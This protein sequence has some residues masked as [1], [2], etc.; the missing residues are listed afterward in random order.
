MEKIDSRQKVGA[1]YRLECQPGF[2]KLF[3]RCYFNAVL[4]EADLVFNK[5]A[6]LAPQLPVEADVVAQQLQHSFQILRKFGRWCAWYL[7][8]DVTFKENDILMSHMQLS[9][10]PIGG[11]VSEHFR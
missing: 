6:Q 2:T 4:I 11:D 3:T 9:P 5:A 10:C 7:K 8:T 1:A